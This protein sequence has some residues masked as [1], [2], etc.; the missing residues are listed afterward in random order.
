MEGRIEDMIRVLLV[1]QIVLISNV[2]AAVLEDEPDMVVIGCAAS[3]DEALAL[4]TKAD[5]VLVST[6]LTSNGALRLTRAVTE[7]DLPAKV[8]VVGL[9]ESETEIL[10]YVQA[11]AAGYV[12]K[13]D[14]VE[15]LT[16]RIR[17]AY[18]E[19]ALISP[20]IAAAL[21]SRVAELANLAAEIRVPSDGSSDLTPREH[22]ILELIGEG[23][24][25]QQIA[26]RLVI[27]VGTVKNH[28]HSI[29]SKLDASNRHDAA[30]FLAI[31]D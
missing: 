10:R 31:F 14:S 2:M 18:E 3:I 12:L 8:L 6:S 24:T 17:S 13:D 21:M 7:A 1:N 26:D 20:K 22:E 29:L 4:A 11:G 5:V 30:A 16:E 25:N 19:K 27:E 15:D 23:L 9:S 28:V